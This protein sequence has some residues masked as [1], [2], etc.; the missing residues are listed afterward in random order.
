VTA[1]GRLQSNSVGAHVRVSHAFVDS[2][3]NITPFIDLGTTRINYGSDVETGAGFLNAHLNA[4]GDTFTAAE[5]GVSFTTSSHIGNTSY[6]PSINLGMTQF[7]GNG[8]TVIAGS[9]EGAP[10][11][12][13]FFSIP[14][15]F[16]RTVFNIA[17][18]LTLNSH[19]RH[20]EVTVGADY[21]VSN[22]A[23]GL[24]ASISVQQKL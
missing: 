22:R 13:P 19:P 3:T 18:A 14:S 6:S 10:A 21:R 23:N 1:T 16:D 20:F 24:T 2:K 7:I 15:Q 17:P 5:A 11:G 8:Q 12:T 9:L 4:H